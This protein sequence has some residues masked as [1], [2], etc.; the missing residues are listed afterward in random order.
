MPVFE[1]EFEEAV[2]FL[3]LER[4]REGKSGATTASVYEIPLTSLERAAQLW[5]LPAFSDRTMDHAFAQAIAK[6][7][8]TAVAEAIGNQ[9][10]DGKP[11]TSTPPAHGEEV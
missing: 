7:I 6:A 2:F 9:L 1:N 3:M 10:A 11:A 4:S 8:D 5:C